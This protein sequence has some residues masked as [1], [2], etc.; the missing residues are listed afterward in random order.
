IMTNSTGLYRQTIFYPYSWALQYAHG[1][2]LQVAVESPAYE[3]TS[4]DF[5]DRGGVHTESV[6]YVDVSGTF[7]KSN[8]QESV[9]LFNRD[10]AN[11]RDVDLLWEDAAPSRV[12]D[13]FI[14]TGNDL[15]A[16]NGFEAPQKVSP[17]SFDKPTT[18][19][20]RTRLQLPAR[21]YTVIN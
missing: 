10:L 20:N 11:A 13:A 4:A 7:D 8:R 5:H 14:L 19:N 15:K 2:A 12:I 21:S 1:S 3:A 9:F 16:A 6:P 17:Q 18:A